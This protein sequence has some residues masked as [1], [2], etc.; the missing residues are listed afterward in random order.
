MAQRHALGWG[1]VPFTGEQSTAYRIDAMADG[2]NLGSPEALLE[3]IKSLLTDGSLVASR[4]WDNREAPIR[5]R[6]SARRGEAAG[7]ALAA[8]ER[9]LMEQVLATSKP[10]LWWTPP[11]QDA[12]TSYFDVVAAKL[13]RDNDDDWDFD[14]EVFEYRFYLLTLTCLPFARGAEPVV[15]PAIPVPPAEET[16]VTIDDASSLTGWSVESSGFGGIERQNLIVD[17]KPVD[18]DGWG[19]STGAFVGLGSFKWHQQGASGAPL[20][21]SPFF[22]VAPNTSYTVSANLVD[23]AARIPGIQH[24]DSA[25][26]AL[27]WFDASGD[28][29][30]QSPWTTITPTGDVQRPKRTATSPAGARRARVIIQGTGMWGGSAE[31]GPLGPPAL[32][33]YRQL[34]VSTE[35]SGVY[36]DGDDPAAGGVAFQWDAMADN[37][38]STAYIPPAA[39]VGP[40]SLGRPDSINFA[41][42]TLPSTVERH[43]RLVRDGTVAMSGSPY[44]RVTA[45][46]TS[47]S[48]A[49][50][51]RVYA[52][53]TGAG[54]ATELS[55]VAVVPSTAFVGNEYYFETGDFDQLKVEYYTS[56]GGSPA[57]PASLN[58]VQIER[59]DTIRSTSTTRQRSRTAV[60]GGSAP[61]QAAIQ[62][63]DDDPAALGSD[64]LVHTSSN[65]AWQ[66]ALRADCLVSSES[67]SPDASAAS[68]S[69]NDLT[70]PMV[71][72]IP[73]ARFTGGRYALM[74][75][76][77]VATTA[78]VSWSAKMVDADGDPIM[79]SNIVATGAASL[80]ATSGA[81]VV[82][83][84]G[85]VDLPV[86]TVEGDQMVELALTGNGNV[87]VDEVW[88]FSLH[89]GV[90]TWVRNLPSATWIE[91]RSP[92]LGA[93]R[94][95]VYAGTGAVGKDGECVDWACA[96]FGTHQFTPGLMQ[97]YTVTTSS[98]ASQSDMRFYKRYLDHVGDDAA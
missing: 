8:A 53:A 7:P 31:P 61:T 20:K 24:P 65:A 87:T 89:D 37:S 52:R 27:R 23:P 41:S 79:S 82:S 78:S 50:G 25:R 55:P 38:I 71:F 33:A 74:A 26:I 35:S 92:Q 2:T 14:E 4:G 15:V 86:V 68:G 17:P 97:V 59:T 90:L 64:I 96:S 48:N 84:L 45:R 12:E 88:L 5:L 10:A 73:G 63:F 77:E 58:V 72:R 80:P 93:E 42:T 21:G 81:Y 9:V 75:R 30:S 34:L 6:L 3:S 32:L 16:S 51:I 29:I 28:E 1:S 70:T 91:I 66:P 60:V 95:S 94:P 67:P 18:N 83:G 62:L 36:F 39:T 85:A 69:I 57:Y 44:L 40:P 22:T 47:P 11:A 49:D 43:L 19:G 76:A 54:T 13:V 98:E 56:S 46:G